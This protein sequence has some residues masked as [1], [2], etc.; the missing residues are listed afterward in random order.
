M[1]NI[2]LDSNCYTYLIDAMASPSAPR[3]A[4]ADQ[5]IALFRVF[6][7]RPGGLYLTP[8]VRKEFEAIRSPDRA[9]HHQSWTT[10]FP[11]TQPIDKAGIDA[12]TSDLERSHGDPGDCRIVAEAEDASLTCILT[13]DSAF[14]DNLSSHTK[15]KLQ[16]PLDFWNSLGIAKG[17]TPATV[18]SDDNPLSR[19]TWWRWI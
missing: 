12:R 7:Y 11:E 14:I 4:L 18:P 19:E 2:G 13:F 8:T 3:D 1:S 15:M 16:R 6:L 17:V 9:A 5:R 10:L